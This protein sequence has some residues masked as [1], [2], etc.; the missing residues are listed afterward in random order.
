MA[1]VRNSPCDWAKTFLGARLWSKEEQMLNLLRDHNRVAI[2]SANSVGKTFTAMVEVAVYLEAHCP[3]YAV[4]TSS[5]WTGVIKS[6]FPE[7]KRIHRDSHT[8]LGGTLLNTEWQ[9]GIQWGAFGVSP[10]EPE[11]FAGFRTPNGLLV[12]IDEASSLEKDLYDAIMGLCANSK[13]RVLMIGNPLRPDGP[14]ADAFYNSDW[15]TMQISAFDVPNITGNEE[16][17]D[18]LA[19]LKWIEERKAEWGEDSPT[20]GSRVKGQFPESGSN[21]VV[22]RGWKDRIL[23][24]PEPQGKLRMGLDV[25]RFGG[26]RTMFVIRDDVGVRH[27]RSFTGIDLMETVGWATALADQHHV[28]FHEMYIDDI[29]VGGGVVDRLH[30]LGHDVNGVNF[31]SGA[32]DSERFAN[33]RAE[34]Y[35]NMRDALH[36]D[37]GGRFKLPPHNS[38]LINEVHMA[39]F[40]YT[41]KGQIKVEPKDDIKKRL[42]RSPDVADALALTFSGK[43]VEE[44]IV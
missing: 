7:L 31:G 28:P 14:F 41:S 2:A 8:N 44:F 5:S 12:V 10:K 43:N 22:P 13:A 23:G 25:A 15:A 9:R 11:N 19:D 3:G 18:G 24:V 17:I 29:G 37:N 39:Q 1:E 20:Y 35:W 42:G 30:E 36:P 4:I 33:E 16:P 32:V 6:L 38:E 27:T 40:S 34:C 26:D 21:E